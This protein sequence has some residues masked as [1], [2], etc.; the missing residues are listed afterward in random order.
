MLPFSMY[1]LVFDVDV[2]HYYRL[3]AN[4]G[5]F[6][7]VCSC[8]SDQSVLKWNARALRIGSRRNDPAHGSEPLSSPAPV[9]QGVVA[10]KMYACALDLSI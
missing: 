10:G 4:L 2:S 9:G 1:T 8:R 3:F 6:S 7:F 5:R